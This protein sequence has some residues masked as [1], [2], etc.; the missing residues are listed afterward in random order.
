MITGPFVFA[1]VRLQS[2]ST[3]R[4]T[5]ADGQII[6]LKQQL[7]ITE[8]NLAKLLLINETLWEIIRDKLKLSENDLNDKLYEIDMRDGKLDEKN[9]RS[10]TECPNCQR[11]VSPRH[12]ACIYCGTII[13]N[14]VFT[15][16][17]RP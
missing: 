11:K 10:I 15:L 6:N 4:D 7:K 16:K 14:S 8:A 17:N 13:D 12:P 9:Q 3:T 1:N 5:S 2:S